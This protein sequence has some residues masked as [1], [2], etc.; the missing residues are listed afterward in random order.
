MTPFAAA[1]ACAVERRGLIGDVAELRGLPGEPGVVGV[2]LVTTPGSLA[3]DIARRGA[4]SLEIFLRHF[5][6]QMIVMTP[7]EPQETALKTY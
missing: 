7:A 4:A 6:G 3:F 2:F 5:S 1:V